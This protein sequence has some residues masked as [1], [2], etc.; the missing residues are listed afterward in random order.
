MRSRYLLAVLA[1]LLLAASFPKIGIAGMAWVAPALMV[2]AALGKSGGESFRIGYVAGLAYYLASLYWLLL[3]PYRWHSIPLGP[4][5]GWLSLSAYLALYPATWVWLLSEGRPATAGGR[6]PNP[7]APGAAEPAVA[8]LRGLGGVMARSWGRRT[9]WAI[10]GAALWVALEMVVARLLT[11]FPWNLLG[12]SQY[13]MTP[14]IQIASV[15][16]IYGVS[17]LVV[18]V[19]LVAALGRTDDRAA[20]DGALDLGGRDLP[21]GDSGGGGLQLWLPATPRRAASPAH[22]PRHAGPAEHS[23]NADLGHQPGPGAVRRFDSSLRASPDQPDGFAHLAGSR[24]AQ[25]RPLG[26]QHL[27]GHHQPRPPA[28]RVADSWLGRPCPCQAADA[29][30]WLRVLQRELPRQ[31]G[32]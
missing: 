32:R 31:P 26:H 15:T 24:G 16:G 29:G 10:S 18:W 19:S 27:P 30:R 23:A 20:T 9:L 6:G 25:F 11:G 3:I 7:E 17:F 12:S 13:Q 21:A 5:A 2:A 22:A 14:L 28:P 4:A 8:R 1:G